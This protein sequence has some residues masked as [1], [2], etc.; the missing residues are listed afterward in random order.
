MDARGTVP[1]RR[2]FAASFLV[3]LIPIVGPHFVS[4]WGIVLWAEV[5]RGEREGNWLACDLALA[6][7]LQVAAVVLFRAAFRLRGA[8]RYV[9]LL[10]LAP[11]FVVFLNWS[12]MIAIPIRFLI[13]DVDSPEK[14]GWPVACTVED[15]WIA[16]V[17]AGSGLALERAG[18]AFL[19]R[20]SNVWG[21]LRMPGC[22]VRDLIAI[23]TGAPQHVSPG[24]AMLFH[25]WDRAAQKDEVFVLT[26]G[27]EEPSRV[28]PPDSSPWYPLLSADGTA[29]AWLASIR[30][31][32]GRAVEH[33]IRI[34]ALG[35][36]EERSLRLPAQFE[37]VPQLVGFDASAPELTVSFDLRNV[38]G[39]DLEGGVAWGPIAPPQMDHVGE[40]FARHPGGFVCW[41]VYREKER[42]R[43]V[44]QLPSGNGVH[45]IPK[46]RSISSITVDPEGRFVAVST[47]PSLSIGSVS[48]AI[49]VFSARNGE[50]VY[51]RSLPA[52]SRSQL[53]FLGP[54]FLAATRIE[55]GKSFVEVLSVPDSLRGEDALPPARR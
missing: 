23:E 54:G 30:T 18:V 15:A 44:Y 25:L 50:D 40:N 1:T 52:Y 36:G 20:A 28:D 46:G 21:I 55:D 9:V 13:E 6:M 12:Y 41:D 33:Q 10:A 51:R 37:R 31:E 4:L 45:E 22:E 5:T 24:G 8:I 26:A 32:D 53:A 3:Y 19:H 35:T 48:D 29:L 49:Y 11:L 16:P 39:L 43:I 47:S 42:H 34:R 14:T 7:F 17:R 2:S 27:S 38:V